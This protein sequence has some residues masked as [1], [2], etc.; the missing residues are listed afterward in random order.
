MKHVIAAMALLLGTAPAMATSVEVG[1]GNWS[2]IP[3]LRQ[4]VD[5][6]DSNAVAAIYEMVESGQC[7]IEGQRKGKLD[8]TVPFL[9]QINA[10]GVVERLVIEKMGCD[11]AEGVLAGAILKMIDHGS[12]R[13]SGGMREGWFRSQVSFSH[14]EDS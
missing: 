5:S 12:F 13:P 9:L 6:L 3:R 8:M 11:K 1:T 10:S 2:N 4:T 7:V 14:Y